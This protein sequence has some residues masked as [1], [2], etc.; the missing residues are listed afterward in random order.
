M[1]MASKDANY[2]ICTRSCNNVLKRV[3]E[4]TGELS[5]EY[6][7]CFR[8]TCTFAH[9]MSELK[10]PK[11]NY[12]VYC[13]RRNG[14]REKSGKL[15]TSFKCQFQHPDESSEEFYMRTGKERPDLPATSEKSRIPRSKKQMNEEQ[16]KAIADMAEDLEK[17]RL[18]PRERDMTTLIIPIPVPE[19]LVIRVPHELKEQ[20]LQIA[21]SRCFKDFKIETF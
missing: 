6:G 15:D 11:C 14:R 16:E 7:V 17:V 13:N 19:T 1:K 12:G 8:E 18:E 4:E 10:L 2:F 20:A 21:I 3:N 5:S 9:S